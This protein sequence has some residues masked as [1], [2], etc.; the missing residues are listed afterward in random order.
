M[1]TR[2]LDW[3]QMLEEVK[4]LA[5]EIHSSHFCPNF[6][7]AVARG[8]WIPTRLLSDFL[9]VSKIASIGI[10]YEDA[11]RT[12]SRLYSFPEPIST[13]DRILLVEDMVETGASI[14]EAERLLTMRTA[15]VKTASLYYTENTLRPPDF[16]LA[17]LTQR[18]HFPW[19]LKPINTDG[20][21]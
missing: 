13:S 20:V 12:Q 10:C 11:K 8:G 19:E 6:L 17:K 4:R 2:N 18:I 21:P 9:Q 14:F 1:M 3:N 7:V 16:S 5:R 15:T